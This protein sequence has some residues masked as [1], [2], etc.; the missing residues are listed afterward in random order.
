MDPIQLYYSACFI[1][2]RE[3]LGREVGPEE[4][5]SS[6]GISRILI[7]FLARKG[8]IINY[9]SEGGVLSTL[10]KS[11]AALL[12]CMTRYTVKIAHEKVPAYTIFASQN[13]LK[14]LDGRDLRV[15]KMEDTDFAR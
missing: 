1:F 3:T 12:I 8:K 9:L 4:P 2:V 7:C 15:H 5:D 10:T 13:C 6:M 14:G 11:G